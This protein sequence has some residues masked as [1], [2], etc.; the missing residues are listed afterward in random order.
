D[1][2]VAPSRFES[3]GL[4][5]VEAMMFGK[6]TVGCNVGGVPEVVEHEVTGLLVAPD[7]A[8]ALQSALET[9]V[10]N[11]D[12]RKHYGSAG[13]TRYE[14]LFSDCRMAQASIDLYRVVLEKK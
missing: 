3:F 14:Q 7:N 6:P 4:I 5:Y 11:A 9:L 12:L 2:F 1:I 13:R 10:S 8:D